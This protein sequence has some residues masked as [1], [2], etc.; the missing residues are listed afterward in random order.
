MR[1]AFIVKFLHAADLHIDSPL[2]GLDGASGAPLE[3]IRSAPRLALQRL[4]KLAHDEKVDFVIFAG[5]VTDGSWRD[6]GTA[7]FFNA[8]LKALAPIPVFIKRGNHDAEADLLDSLPPLPHVHNFPKRKAATFYVDG[9]PVAVHGQSYAKKAELNDLAANYPAPESGKLNIGVLHTSLTGYDGHDPY[10]PTT[11]ANLIA[12]G[13][14]YWALGHIHMREELC[15]DPLIIYPG[16][17]Q[18]R[19]MRETG[20]KGCYIVEGEKGSLKARFCELDVVR[21]FECTLDVAEHDDASGAIAAAV[22]Y[23]ESLPQVP[24]RMNAIRL[25]LTGATSAHGELV[26]ERALL[27]EQ[28][29]DR[30]APESWLVALRLDTIP[31]VDLNDLRAQ[32]DWQGALFRGID[33]LKAA[34]QDDTGIA[35]AVKALRAKLPPQVVKDYQL[36]L[37]DPEVLRAALV[38]AE[39]LLLAEIYR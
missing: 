24:E 15:Q 11:L 29:R 18:G 4:V 37:E 20:P 26:R 5:D 2:R 17:L 14:D 39:Q 9:I 23:I 34:P 6:M 30:V 33:A 38:A 3:K 27:E 19:H 1:G 7:S 8:Q 13:Y 32:D 36:D 28:L 22:A 31:S 35:S 25:T 12:R 10:A 21:W 16:N